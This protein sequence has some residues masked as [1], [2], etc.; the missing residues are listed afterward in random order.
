M[1]YINGMIF[2][3]L[4]WFGTN[5]IG[6]IKYI[7]MR[8]CIV[9]I[10][11]D[12]HMLYISLIHKY[13]M[14]S[15]LTIHIMKSMDH[16]LGSSMWMII[17]WIWGIKLT[18]TSQIIMFGAF[19]S[20]S[21]FKKRHFLYIH[22]RPGPCHSTWELFW[23]TEARYFHSETK[24]LARRFE[25][26][27]KR[28]ALS[29]ELVSEKKKTRHGSHGFSMASVVLLSWNPVKIGFFEFNFGE[30]HGTLLGLRSPDD[31]SHWVTWDH[32]LESV[33]RKRQFFFG[34]WNNWSIWSITSCWSMT[35]LDFWKISVENIL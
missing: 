8:Y 3:D 11:F 22:C 27:L 13:S 23:K 12:I 20:L 2:D 18:Y 1:L 10:L 4:V 15:F 26:E 24:V 31:S 29:G 32:R 7:Q 14:V 34:V 9:L 30:T 6:M 25:D 17:S 5:G 28:P 21:Q 16:V 35:F 19:L 33:V